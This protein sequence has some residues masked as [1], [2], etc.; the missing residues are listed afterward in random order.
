MKL[1]VKA[2]GLSLGIFWGVVLCATTLLAV[3]TGYLTNFAE[4]MADVYPYYEVTLLGS[5]AGLVWGF[6]DGLIAGL[7]FG[8]L[9]NLFAPGSAN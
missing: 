8:W 1:S 2:L 7:I 6:I 4:M 3:Y 9:Y 5:V